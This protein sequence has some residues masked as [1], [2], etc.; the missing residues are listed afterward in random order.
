LGIVKGMYEEDMLDEDSIVAWHH[1]TRGSQ[2]G[3]RV[4][5]L[6]TWLETA[7]EESDSSEGGDSE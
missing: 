6:V 1:Q 4:Q 5:P 7:A 3:I 2:I